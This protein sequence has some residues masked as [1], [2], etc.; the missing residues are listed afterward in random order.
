M[1]EMKK[2]ECR[3][4]KAEDKAFFQ[5]FYDENRE[6]VYYLAA[7]YASTDEEREK[8]VKAALGRLLRHIPTLRELDRWAAANYLEYIVS[9]A[10]W[11]MK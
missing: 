9:S 6:F 11:D 8:L 7:K 4:S 1:S 3:F 5:G 2:R 10:W